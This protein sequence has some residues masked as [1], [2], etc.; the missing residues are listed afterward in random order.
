MTDIK[1]FFNSFFPTVI[2]NTHRKTMYFHNHDQDNYRTVPNFFSR[3]KRPESATSIT[4]VRLKL[5]L[6]LWSWA[7]SNRKKNKP[8]SIPNKKRWL[9]TQTGSGYNLFGY[10]ILPRN[11]RHSLLLMNDLLKT[12]RYSAIMPLTMFQESEKY[13]SKFLAQS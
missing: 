1:L 5:F 3:T 6:V 8:Y 9:K 7:V 12:T 2:H 10:D 11:E 4:A 13:R